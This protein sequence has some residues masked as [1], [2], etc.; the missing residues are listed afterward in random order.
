[1]A[2]AIVAWLVFGG[3]AL[4][5]DLPLLDPDVTAYQI[6]SHNKQGLN[7]DGGW[8]LHD[9]KTETEDLAGWTDFDAGASARRSRER[10]AQGSWALVHTVALKGRESGWRSVRK[11]LSE[12]LNFEA[13]DRLKLRVWPTHA[14]GGIDY[15]VR[16]DSGGGATQ[17][18]IR[19][20]AP[21]RWNEVVLDVSRVPRVG[22]AA[23][24]L[25]FHLDWGA[26][27]GMQ[28][29][30]DD[31]AFLQPDGRALLVDDFEKG[32]L[33]AVLFDAMGPGAIKTIWGLG[34]HDI[35]IEID[36]RTAIDASQD[37]FFQG[38]VPGFP[39][40][41]VRKACV[42]S[43]PWKCIAHYSFVPIGFAERCRVTTGHPKPFYHIIAERTRDPGRFAPWRPDQD[44]EPLS[45][46]W[47]RAGEDPKGWTDLRRIEGAANPGPGAAVVLADVRGAGAIGALRLKLPPGAKAALASLWLC[48]DWD[49][50]RNDVEAPLGF[51]FG[52]GVRWQAIPSRVIGIRGDEGYCFLP[53]P[54]W[55]RARVRLENRGGAAVGPIG[56]S[57]QWR[58]RPYPAARSARLRTCFRSGPTERGRDWLFFKAEGRGQYVGVVHRLIGGHYCEGDI[59]FHIDGSRSPAFYGTGSED[60]YHQACWPNIDNHTPF[61]GCVG[62]VAEEAKNAPGKTFYDFPACYYRFHLEAP[63]RF[64]SS[65]HCAIEHGGVNETDSLY[66]SL[67][68][69]YV[70]DD[71]GL[72]ETDRVDFT[73]RGAAVLEHFFEGD[74]DD[75]PVACR[76]LETRAPLDIVLAI[77]GANAGV[78]LRRT[79]DQ[80]RGPQRAAVLVDGE[81][82]GVWY[83]PDRNTFKRLAESDFEVRPALVRGKTS[84]RV[85]FTPE[86]GAWTIGEL[87]A[88]A[89]TAAP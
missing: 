62:D 80:A 18:D 28:F 38:R 10:V 39:E 68:F 33:R 16:I 5:E 42:A 37:D 1:M 14:D 54:F 55:E 81:S 59:R 26:V 49:G 21:G 77:D 78:R 36:G 63:V 86:E 25:L 83:D 31:I 34:G 12:G 20:L 85:T 46:I 65:V 52:A 24:W 69:A 43:G 50:G 87:R 73:E 53:M 75:V 11:S 84:I 76:I 30:V 88:Y 6:S 82:A 66:A 74:D 17:L 15:A 23:F 22:V 47:S 51:F 40:P 57:V 19:D 35:R 29:F 72:R 8:F 27:D 71:P 61:H 7:G 89:H 13:C 56:F 2:P 41:L 64:Q 58:D 70:R 79:L 48:M 60:Y 67:A 3:A 45:A 32:R 9:G 4:V 44:L